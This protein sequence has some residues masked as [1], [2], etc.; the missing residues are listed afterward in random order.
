MAD[1]YTYQRNKL[2]L[3]IFKEIVSEKKG[4]LLFLLAIFTL[5]IG[6]TARILTPLFFKEIIE[7]LNGAT[8][9]YTVTITWF[10]LY[11]VTW[12]F[13]HL[14]SSIEEMSIHRVKERCFT[15]L[16]SRIINKLFY[17]S[18]KFF[19]TQKIGRISNVVIR[20]KQDL[21]MIIWGVIFFITPLV[22]ELI[23]AIII[24][25]HYF[26]L[27]YIIILLGI[28]LVL[29]IYTA[30]YSKKALKYRENANEIDKE[31]DAKVI[32]YVQNYEFVKINNLVRYVTRFL[33]QGLKDRENTQVLAL[34]KHSYVYIGQGIIISLSF[35]LL[36]YLLGNDVLNHKI[37]IGDFV[38]FHGYL[39][40]FIAPISMLGYFARDI[41]K[42]LIDIREGIKILLLKP[43]IKNLSNSYNLNGTDKI[44]I[45]FRDVHFKYENKVI[46][47]NVSFKVNS[48]EKVI[49]IGETG[50]GKSTMIKLLLRLYDVDRGEILINGINIKNVKLESIYKILGVV[51]QDISLF[52]DTIYNNIKFTNVYASNSQIETVIEKAELSNLYGQLSGKNQLVGEKGVKLSGGEKQRIS[53]A[54]LFLKNPIAC[55]LDEPTFSLDNNTKE[56]IIKNLTEFL[57]NKTAI[58]VTHHENDFKN[59]DKKILICNGKIIEK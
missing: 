7:I 57:K 53:I 43:E 42:A 16:I 49:I 6:S 18:L 40:Q 8:K 26:S 11:G 47:N 20:L 17:L 41:R 19:L 23:I 10:F 24:L 21:A 15:I 4:L 9:N 14:S 36:I 28:L 58:I 27:Y 3:S 54:R 50:V 39:I 45:E 22:I 30:I 33:K 34:S 2:L 46:L 38:M 37:S 5:V 12:A 51:S 31:F 32:D 29:V 44:S 35:V 52:N 25:S 1:Q 55:L 13:D 48:G 56:K 59:Y